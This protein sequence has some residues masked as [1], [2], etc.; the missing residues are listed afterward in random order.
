MRTKYGQLAAVLLL[1][2]FILGCVSDR[3]QSGSNQ[4][5]TISRGYYLL[6]GTNT[7][8]GAAFEVGVYVIQKGDTLA[9][10]AHRFNARS[11][12]ILAINPGLDSKKLRV[13]Q[14]IRIYEQRKSQDRFSN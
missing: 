2:Q 13:G 1:T 4:T 11:A 9:R 5:D 14:Q 8:P 6:S 7:T 10:I 12:E 3:H